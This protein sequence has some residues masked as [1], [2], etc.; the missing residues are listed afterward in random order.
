MSDAVVEETGQVRWQIDRKIPVALIV[1]LFFQTAAGVWWVAT[2]TQRLSSLEE[3]MSVVTARGDRLTRVE[4]KVESAIDGIGEIK[5]IL[6]NEPP[7][8]KRVD[9]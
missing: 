8:P 9:P 3:K 1:S 4:V 2:A 6:R 7:M 5:S